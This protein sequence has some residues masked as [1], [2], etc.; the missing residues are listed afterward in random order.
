MIVSASYRTDIPTFYGEWFMNRLDAGYCKVIN[1]YNRRAYRV[2]LDRG[3]VDAFVF[4]TK[5]LGPFMKHLPEVRRRGYPFVVQHTING[6]P[7]EL[8]SAVVDAQKAVEHVRLLATEHGPRTC[9]WRYD[10]ILLTSLTP[11]E[12]HLDN[13][14]RLAQALEGAVDEVVISFAH[15]Y[16]KTKTNLDSASSELGFGWSD[17]AE[18]WK[19]DFGSRL[20]EI[21]RDHGQI[22]SVCSQPEFLPS[23]ANEARCV[24]AERLKDCGAVGARP[25]QKGNRE[26]CRCHKSK[27]IGDYDTC[28]HG[29]VYCYAVRNQAL[30]K[31]RYQRHDPSGE[32][33][34]PPDPATLAAEPERAPRTLPLF[35]D[36]G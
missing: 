8:E 21:A 12:F 16:R 30:A 7:R 25:I 4:W 15:I 19:R 13:F 1:P 28:P 20:V 10:T 2:D 5:N 32:F 17:P 31:T 14:K 9:V 34:F 35:P 22:V 23:G 36:D 18:E 3:N 11:P 33:L 29:C 26:S 24:D 6:Y 27:D